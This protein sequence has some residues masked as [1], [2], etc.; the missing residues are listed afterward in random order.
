MVKSKRYLKKNKQKTRRGGF[1]LNYIGLTKRKTKQ[2][3]IIII[4]ND[5]SFIPTTFNDLSIPRYVVNIQIGR[6]IIPLFLKD[7]ICQ[8]VT[9][10]KNSANERLIYHGI[11]LT[12]END[13]IFMSGN[14]KIEHNEPLQG[15]WEIE[16][17]FPIKLSLLEEDSPLKLCDT[18]TE[19]EIN[20]KLLKNTLYD[21]DSLY[22]KEEYKFENVDENDSETLPNVSNKGNELLYRAIQLLYRYLKTKYDL[23]EENNYQKGFENFS[24]EKILVSIQYNESD[25]I[26]I[27]LEPNMDEFVLN[28]CYIHNSAVFD[29]I[30]I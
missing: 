14:F 2:K 13:A 21:S 12:K 16:E 8:T 17:M 3:P 20:K 11:L 29:I 6:R 30:A 15:K 25:I 1:M 9:E 10:L 28:C 23:Y 18:Q 22:K 27:I 7:S 26:E 5:F 24:E 19:Y 4:D